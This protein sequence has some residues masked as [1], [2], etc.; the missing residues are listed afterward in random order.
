[1]EKTCPNCGRDLRCVF[2]GAS[3][4]LGREDATHQCDIFG[5]F[6]CDQYFI[7]GMN[8]NLTDVPPDAVVPGYTIKPY[9][10]NAY[11][12]DY[13]SIDS[14]TVVLLPSAIKY[15][16]EKC[17]HVEEMKRY[18]EKSSWSVDIKEVKR[19][20]SKAFDYEGGTREF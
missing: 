14:G 7:Y 4:L 2:T 19:E 18:V 15:I 12:G 10:E 16:S 1:M 11:R 13:A 17:G 3:V 9:P 6:E 20:V 8:K 5:C